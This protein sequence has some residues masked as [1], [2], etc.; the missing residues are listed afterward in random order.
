MSNF[1][2]SFVSSYPV[3]GS[4]SRSSVNAQSNVSTPAGGV[5][6]GVLVILA[7]AF[8]TPAF[9]YIPSACLGAG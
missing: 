3:T 8:L 2:G 5:M 4:F 7:L 1:F 6:V 9:E